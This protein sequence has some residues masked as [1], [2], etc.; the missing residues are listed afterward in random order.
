MTENMNTLPDFSGLGTWTYTPPAPAVLL[1]AVRDLLV[2]NPDRHDQHHW[3]NNIFGSAKGIVGDLRQYTTQELPDEAEDEDNPVC[4]TTACV[5]GW[6]VIL[7]DDPRARITDYEVSFS[8]RTTTVADRA[9]ELLGLTS[10]QSGWLFDA[11][12][13]RDDIIEALGR[14][15]ED[16]QAE[17]WREPVTMFTVKVFDRTGAEV[18]SKDVEVDQDD[19]VWEQ[20]DNALSQVFESH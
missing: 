8:G 20:V 7:G 12:R 2:Y 19:N 14:L 5:A 17:I 6:T 18:H 9:R 11:Y 16:P 15:I 13:D 3:V 10:E 1:A 4:G